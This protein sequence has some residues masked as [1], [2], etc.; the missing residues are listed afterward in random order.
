MRA[1]SLAGPKGTRTVV[2]LDND[3]RSGYGIYEALD[4]NGNII[5]TGRTADLENR[6]ASHERESAWWPLAASFR[7]TPCASYAEAVALERAAISTD[8]G[9]FNQAG[10]STIKPGRASVP[11]AM[12]HRITALYALTDNRGRSVD[13][14]NYLAT[15]RS[16][17]WSLVSLGEP[18]AIT[19]EAVRQRILR[20][21][22]DHDLV[23]PAPPKA[24][25]R[26]G[27]VWP[28]LSPA[29]ASEM[30]ALQV[31]AFKCVGPTPVGHPARLASERLSELLAE[32]KL[33]GVRDREVA[34]AL[35]LS[36]AAIRARLA[37]HGYR[38]NPPSQSSYEP[39][40]HPAFMKVD[41][42]GRGH[43]MDG[44]N[45]RFIN[46]DPARR[47]CRACER[48]RVQRYRKAAA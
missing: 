31:D 43:E 18:M 17:G 5:Y 1:L 22:I 3:G 47:V 30:R 11:A 48:I 44:D 15:A 27:K 26:L 24:P 40:S 10:R 41:R 12:W 21:V 13:L 9:A 36:T 45:L 33:R 28:Q 29:V 37:R 2:E 14:D 39:G 34:E 46:G 35:G 16:L 38:K 19:R 4:C 20:G 42:C 6:L 8:L 7:W 32:A 25:E 23:I